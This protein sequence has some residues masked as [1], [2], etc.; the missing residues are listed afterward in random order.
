MLHVN[1]L[2]GMLTAFVKEEDQSMK[3][4][5]QRNTM[6]MTVGIAKVRANRNNRKIEGYTPSGLGSI[7]LPVDRLP[8]R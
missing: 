5:E 8:S 6:A 3:K 7:S 2:H 4:T 1:T